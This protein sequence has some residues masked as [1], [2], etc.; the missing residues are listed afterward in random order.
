MA[1]KVNARTGFR[2]FLPSANGTWRG[3]ATS[4]QIGMRVNPGHRVFRQVPSQGECAKTGHPGRILRF[5]H[6]PISS[7]LL[8][9]VKRRVGAGEQVFQ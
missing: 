4:G 9:A 6:D 1:E 7:L 2:H 3:T 8:G 5:C